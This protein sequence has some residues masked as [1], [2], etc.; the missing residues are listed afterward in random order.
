M[1]AFPST[2]LCTRLRLH[3]VLYALST[4]S[5]QAPP[6]AAHQDFAGAFNPSRSPHPGADTWKT[7][8]LLSHYLLGGSPFWQLWKFFIKK[9][10]FSAEKTDYSSDMLYLLWHE[11]VF[12]LLLLGGHLMADVGLCGVSLWYMGSLV[13]PSINFMYSLLVH[14]FIHSFIYIHSFVH[15]F[16]QLCIWISTVNLVLCWAFIGLKNTFIFSP[17]SWECPSLVGTARV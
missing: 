9:K 3:Q 8:S 5:C 1:L 2:S 16:A 6:C 13:I 12:L 7:M 4:A 15:S 11:T 14:S 17:W 10:V